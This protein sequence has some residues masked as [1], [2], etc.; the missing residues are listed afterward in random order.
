MKNKFNNGDALKSLLG[1]NIK[2][3]RVNAGYSIEKMA[4]KADISVPF[5]GA[6]ERGE[7]WPSPN[8]LAGIAQGLEVNSYDLL[9]PEGTASQDIT[10]ITKKLIKDMSALVN[11]SLKMINS[12]VQDYNKT[13]I[14]K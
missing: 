14:R 12:V 5:L 8:T 10:K 9:K 4:E 6:I 13:E 1:Q 11:Q 2:R 7:K 3:F